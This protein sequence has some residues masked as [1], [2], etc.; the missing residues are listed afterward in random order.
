MIRCGSKYEHQQK[1]VF[2]LYALYIVTILGSVVSMIRDPTW[3][4]NERKIIDFDTV[5]DIHIELQ[6]I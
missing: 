1:Y 5:W 3:T 4:L 6:K 2:K